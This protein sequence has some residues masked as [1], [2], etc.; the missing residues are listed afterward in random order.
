MK[1]ASINPL[2]RDWHV[3]PNG[4]LWELKQEYRAGSWG[5]YMTQ[6]EAIGA[7]IWQAREGQ[8]SLVVHGR[9]GRISKVWSY[10]DAI[11]PFR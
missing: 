10:D 2:R 4:P 6:A 3:V 1:I 8:V 9:D 5:L 11:V 7:G